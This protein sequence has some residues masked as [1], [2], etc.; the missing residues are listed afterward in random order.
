MNARITLVLIAFASLSALAGCASATPTAAAP[1]PNPI[2]A[3]AVPARDAQAPGPSRFELTG[4]QV[5]ANLAMTRPYAV[6][7]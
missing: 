3:F 6:R 2:V 7:H 4:Y 1:S 5:R